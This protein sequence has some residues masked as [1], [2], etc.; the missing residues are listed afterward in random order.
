MGDFLNDIVSI[1]ISIMLFT[2]SVATMGIAV[3]NSEK[4]KDLNDKS[5][6]SANYE[7]KEKKLYSIYDAGLIA[8][9]NGDKEEYLKIR[10]G[11]SGY[12]MN[13]SREDSQWLS[14][15]IIRKKVDENISVSDEGS[16][17]DYNRLYLGT[18]EG[19]EMK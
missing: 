6:I 12:S 11:M 5:S 4:F 13:S 14:R 9:I 15:W 19:A 2:G 16:L 17:M 3:S 7:T 8:L 10:L 1:L 18:S